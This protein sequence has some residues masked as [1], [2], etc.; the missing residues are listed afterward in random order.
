[1]R[2]KQWEIHAAYGGLSASDLGRIMGDRKLNPF[3][4]AELLAAA[5]AMPFKETGRAHYRALIQDERDH[6]RRPYEQ[7]QIADG[8][9]WLEKLG[10]EESPSVG[11]AALPRYSFAL[12]FRFA[13]ARPYLS[14]DDDAFYII[15]N[16][17]RKD[18][19]FKVPFVAPTSWKGSLR[20]V[21]TQGLLTALAK[22]L[23]PGPPPD[24]AERERLME[25]LW[26]E[27]VRRVVLFGNEKQNDADFINRWLAPRLFPE[28]AGESEQDRRK[29][30]RE[31]IK[32]L[33]KAFNAYLID[34]GYR[35]EKVEGRQGRLF[36]FPTFF[37]A[38][39]L[40]MINPHDRQRRIGKNPI[41]FECVPTRATGTFRLLYAPYDWPG[42]VT[43]DE[44][45]LRKQVQADL[46]LVAAAV[47][48]LLTVYGFGAKTSS[49]YGAAQ[50]RLA[51]E[52]V[53]VIKAELNGQA[54]PSAT[55]PP[56]PDPSLPGYLESPTQLIADLRRPDGSLKSEDE[57]KALLEERGHQ[58]TKK[59]R[60]LY[61]KAKKW[62]EQKGRVLAEKGPEPEPE[63][64]P[65]AAPP[66][67]AIA[68]RS[69]ETLEELETAASALAR[70]LV[71]EMGD[72]A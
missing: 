65:T 13:L 23:P 42:Q 26:A 6:R 17:V 8:L 35:T 47:R 7:A 64:R 58:Y 71:E 45:A 11:L 38:I 32:Q 16:P 15:D 28:P 72:A 22:L 41:L 37:N 57:Y 30:V 25:R 63:S 66:A 4:Q 44:A 49:G 29:R 54:A 50:D 70:E 69:F 34:H 40:E 62:W 27:R 46:P 39:G 20:A 33:D 19:V 68:R 1:M 18:K 31:Q 61:S 10:L 55:V 21:A 2:A 59:R 14:R 51:A 60:Q 67:I 24:E 53:L 48:D 12:E 36:F 5:L 3:T 52:G 56:P 43:P 9:T